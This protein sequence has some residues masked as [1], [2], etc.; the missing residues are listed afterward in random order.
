MHARWRDGKRSKMEDDIIGSRRPLN[1]FWLLA[2]HKLSGSATVSMRF[3]SP[4]FDLRLLPRPN[5]LTASSSSFHITIKKSIHTVAYSHQPTASPNTPQLHT[6]QPQPQLTQQ[7]TCLKIG[8]P[9]PR[10]VARCAPVVQE[11]QRRKSSRANP[12]SMLRGGKEQPSPQR[13]SS[14]QPTPYVSRIPNLHPRGVYMTSLTL[15]Q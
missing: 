15:K 2:C 1:Y 11:D 10:L 8:N 7:A 5:K 14:P 9:S 13:R 3:W 12:L 4:Q 6:P